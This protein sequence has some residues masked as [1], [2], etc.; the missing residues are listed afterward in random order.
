MK[1]AL[2]FIFSLLITT[3]VYA[4][5]KS[6]RLTGK[7]TDVAD[8]TPLVG[9]TVIID[10]S[11]VGTKTDVE[12]T[13]FLTVETGKTYTI[14]ISNVGYEPKIVGGIQ[15]QGTDIS[16]LSIGMER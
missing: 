7:V 10:G 11:S 14:K 13:F 15:V 8:N 2:S 6:A 16:P 4:Q 5:P 3:L 1:G 12:G 9:A